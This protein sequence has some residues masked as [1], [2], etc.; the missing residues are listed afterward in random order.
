[1]KKTITLSIYFLLLSMSIHAQWVAANNGMDNYVWGSAVYNGELYACGNFEHADGNLALAVAKWNGSG[2]SDVGGGF[3]SNAFSNVV[4]GLIIYNNELIAGGYVDS[5]G[6]N[7]IHK[8]ARWNGTS[9]SPMGTDCPISTVNC[10][11]IHNGELYAGGEGSGALRVCV[12]KW[13]GTNWI[14]LDT[15]GS[16]KDVWSLASYNGDLYA[17]GGFSTFNGITAG[18]VV[19][20]DGSTWSD[21]GS[22]LSG[23]NPVRA[24]AV[25]NNKLYIGGAFT[26]AGGVAANNIAAWD[27]TSYS[28]LSGGVNAGVQSLMAYGNKL[29]VGGSYWEVNGISANRAAYWDGS[30]WNVLGTDLGAGAKTIAVYNNE[31]YFGGE[32]AFN[33]QNFFAKWNGGTFTGVQ[34][35]EK[36]IQPV[37]FPDPAVNRLYVK[38]KTGACNLS[39]T[40]IAGNKQHV[41]LL[42]T[43]TTDITELDISRLAPGIYFL[44]SEKIAGAV[45]FIVNR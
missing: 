22:G 20:W 43:E 2:W 16:N 27:G 24:L 13:D 7:P 18:G 37:V 5:A 15:E 45:K 34:Q 28:A 39:V 41:P 17:G 10:F 14:A 40:D 30:G 3:Q 35:T 6:G 32:G 4:R 26:S 12:A 19:K 23:A 9:W 29:F 11:A 25:F 38:M 8:I 44:S 1:M 21:I 36:E 33:G 31:L 42:S